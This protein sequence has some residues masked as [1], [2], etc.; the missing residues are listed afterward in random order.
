MFA[1]F[2]GIAV[3]VIGFVIASSESPAKTYSG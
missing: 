2:I 1:I 3:T